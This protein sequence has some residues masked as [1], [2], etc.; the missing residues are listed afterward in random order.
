MGP[1][2]GIIFFALLSLGV[3]QESTSPEDIN[4]KTNTVDPPPSVRL[5]P[6]I[7]KA[8]LKA[9]TDLEDSESFTVAD[10]T[11]ETFPIDSDILNTR[12]DV[13]VGEANKDNIKIHSF[14]VNGQAA[15]ANTSN[16]SPTFID[17]K[18]SILGT[19]VGNVENYVT[20]TLPT[21]STFS[22]IFQ[23]RESGVNLQQVRSIQ[24]TTKSKTDIAHNKYVTLKPKST[25]STTTT[26]TTTTTTTPKPTHNDDG[27]NIE[28]VDKK[29]VQ[30]FQA[31]LVAAF[32]VH[33]DA[34][35]VPKK[36]IPIYQQTTNQDILKASPTSNVLT[37]KLPIESFPNIPS[38]EFINHQLSLQ[39]QLEEKQ[40][41]L[42]EQLR[43]LQIQQRQQEE[44]LRNQQLFFQQ[45]EALRHQSLFEQ[46]QLKRQQILIEQ[47][48]ISSNQINNKFAVHK[49]TPQSHLNPNNAL[50]PQK[51]QVSIQPSLSFDQSSTL[52]AHQQLPNKEAVDFLINLRRQHPDQFPLQENHLPQGIGSFL[53]PNPIQSFHQASSIQL[54]NQI[55]PTDDQLRQKQGNRVFRHESG[56]G[57]FGI[58]SQNYNRFND[59]PFRNHFLPGN[60]FNP[61]AELKHLL[62]QTNLNSRAHDDLNI[63]S[64]VLSL[65]HGIPINNVSNRLPFD[66]RRQKRTS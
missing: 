22:E 55:R 65:N 10:S 25:V 63:V 30:V 28:D 18:I 16:T 40:R 43:F 5:D 17:D 29:D 51:S 48:K 66:S 6:Y 47:Q 54:S 3:S 38:S 59:A 50:R 19:T 27:E 37:Q 39:K 32:T 12:E 14:V 60:R 52:A 44:L 1:V 7:R 42:E 13:R 41:I 9:L 26:K 23:T 31:P 20:A 58:N 2:L 11:D 33:Q 24:S 35:G 4:E 46:E 15:F 45:K 34:D 53:Q 56:V 49:N 57:N 8:L 64:K 61:D 62:A 36:V 21:Q